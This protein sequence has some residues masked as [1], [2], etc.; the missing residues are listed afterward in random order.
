M[1]KQIKQVIYK[2]VALASVTLLAACGPKVET[3]SQDQP[4]TSSETKS[5]AKLKLVPEFNQLEADLKKAD[6]VDV[7]STLFQSQDA[8]HMSQNAFEVIVDDLRVY[9]ADNADQSLANEF[10]H[11]TKAGAVVVMHTTIKNNAKEDFY[12]PIEELRLSYEEAAAKVYPSSALYPESS[13]NLTEILLANKGLLKAGDVVEGYLVYG[14]GQDSLQTINKNGYFYLTVVPPKANQNDLVGTS[15]SEFGMEQKLFLPIN[16][17]QSQQILAN[18]KLIQDRLVSEWWGNKTLLAQEELNQEV[19]QEG[20]KVKLKRMEIADF[21]PHDAYKDSFQN[22]V[23]GQIIV[24]AELELINESQETILPVDG[25][26][27]LE[28]EGEPINSDY[29]L[30]N[31]SY[32]Q[33]VKPGESMRFIK[34]F[35]LDKKHYQTVWQDKKMSLQID[36]PV[37]SDQI[38]NQA[39]QSESTDDT[40]NVTS[41]QAA[42][43][44]N[45]YFV[46]FEWI[47]T[48]KLF[49]DDQLN[50][51]DELETTSQENNS[52]TT[53]TETD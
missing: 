19:N 35:A 32:G 37:Q 44:E 16:E 33:A 42:V 31:E 6:K 30:I 14:L 24:T 45:S 40:Q 50:R 43:S 49:I 8:F 25:M 3:G 17:S 2:L 23:Y 38:E 26:A 12:F 53:T 51:V 1:K 7:S 18:D 15:Q 5:Q 34:V 21:E 46:E 47:P 29:V 52:D 36:L 9:K 10:N 41:D 22:F 48:L 39:S 4:L 20:L 11:E 28:I 27:T 13:G